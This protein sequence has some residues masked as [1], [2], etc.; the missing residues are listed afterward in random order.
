M[1]LLFFKNVLIHFD[2]VMEL[3]I[4]AVEHAPLPQKYNLINEHY[5]SVWNDN[6]IIGFYSVN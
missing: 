6:K 1:I 4:F 3:N 2:N 5:V